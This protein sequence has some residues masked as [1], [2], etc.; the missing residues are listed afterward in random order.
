MNECDGEQALGSHS[1][2]CGSEPGLGP[3]TGSPTDG[4][5]MYILMPRSEHNQ[6]LL[7]IWQRV[8]GAGLIC[9]FKNINFSFVLET[10]G[11]SASVHYIRSPPD[12]DSNHRFPSLPR[13]DYSYHWSFS[14]CLEFLKDAAVLFSLPLFDDS[15]V[16]IRVQEVEPTLMPTSIFLFVLWGAKLTF[17]LSVIQ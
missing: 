9:H 7:G 2:G 15:S 17:S 12:Y 5:R 14:S 4:L 11:A 1:L 6:L 10:R 3:R 16:P 8:Q 13:V